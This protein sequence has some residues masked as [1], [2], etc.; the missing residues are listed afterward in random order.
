MMN[1]YSLKFLEMGHNN[2]L[3]NLVG[4]VLAHGFLSIIIVCP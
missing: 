2:V 3:E 1:T 4:T